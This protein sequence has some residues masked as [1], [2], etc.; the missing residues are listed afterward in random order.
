M[1]IMEMTSVDDALPRDLCNAR[2]HIH[3]DDLVAN[4]A[5]FDGNEVDAVCVCQLTVRLIM[6]FL[7]AGAVAHALLSTVQGIRHTQPS[8]RRA[9][10]PSPR[11]VSRC[12]W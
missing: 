1:L 11:K 6:C 12:G 7:L 3:V 5:A 9:A 8:S 10:G 4:S 2:G